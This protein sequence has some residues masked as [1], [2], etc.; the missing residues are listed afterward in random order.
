MQWDDEAYVLKSVPRGENSL[1]LHL[2]TRSHGRHAGLV[3]G[4]RGARN[5][6]AYEAGGLLQV[7][8]RARLE[9]HLGVFTCESLHSYAALLFDDPDRLAALAAA[10]AL[11]EAG[12]PEREAVPAVFEGFGAL[13]TALTEKESWLACYILFELQFLASTGFGIDLSRCAATGAVMDLAYV[14]PR[15]G[16]AV[17]REAGTPWRDKLL[18][19]PSFLLVERPYE[20]LPDLSLIL[21]GLTLTGYFIERHLEAPPARSRFVDRLRQRAALSAPV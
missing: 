10:A 7:S 19:L 1:V 4:G 13:M 11:V 3:R 6:G 18:P 16:Q 5:R 9:G 21:D 8:W 12:V 17:S 15:S 2:L 20:S 14:S